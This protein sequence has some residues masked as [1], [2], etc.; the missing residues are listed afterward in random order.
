MA[1]AGMHAEQLAGAGNL[2]TLGGAAMGLQFQ[3]R[4]RSIAWHS[5]NPRFFSIQRASMPASLCFSVSAGTIVPILWRRNRCERLNSA[6]SSLRLNW[7]DLVLLLRRRLFSEP[8]TPPRHYLPCAAW[9]RWSPH[10]RFRPTGESSWRGRLPGAPFRV[11]G[12]KSWREPCGLRRGSGLSGSCEP[13][14][15]VPQWLAGTSL[16]SAPSHGCFYAARAPSCFVDRE[17][18]RSR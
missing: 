8:A 15:R 9:F 5:V 16:L 17:T 2:K 18:C 6:D 13:E 4:F 7:A 10:R 12:E 14:N 1:L 3:F 11:R